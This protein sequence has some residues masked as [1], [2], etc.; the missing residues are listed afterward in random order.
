MLVERREKRGRGM[1]VDLFNA[2]RSS[3]ASRRSWIAKLTLRA[4]CDCVTCVGIDDSRLAD[5][6]DLPEHLLTAC[7][8]PCRRK[9]PGQESAATLM[10]RSDG[11]NEK[12]CAC[13]KRERRAVDRPRLA[14]SRIPSGNVVHQ[15][16]AR[17]T[18]LI[19]RDVSNHRDQ[20]G[21]GIGGGKRFQFFII[22]LRH[23]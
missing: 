6:S 12:G 19:L 16:T 14:A 2:S 4:I 1:G 7:A 11:Y 5:K 21:P 17:V 10:R 22:T 15:P 23:A 20:E 8:K 18:A 9:S 13:G 3:A